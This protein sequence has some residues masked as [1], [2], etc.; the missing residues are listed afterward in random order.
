M[1]GAAN[2][3]GLAAFGVDF[4]H[5]GSH[6]PGGEPVRKIG[7]SDLTMPANLKPVAPQA[8]TASR[9]VLIPVP[10]V[11]ALRRLQYD[12]IRK[13][14]DEG[15][16]LF[17][18]GFV[19]VWNFASRPDGE[20]DL[21]FWRDEIEDTRATA[22]LALDDVLARILPLNRRNYHAGQVT[23]LF[24]LTPNSLARLRRQL[25]GHVETS[26]AVFPRAGLESFLRKRW[27]GAACG[28]QNRNGGKS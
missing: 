1:P 6:R 14:V 5:S 11:R 22:K 2:S 20:R 25:G 27:L 13:L 12:A 18:P 9:S 4:R 26:G 8:N 24:M 16:D 19:W 10:G 17:N 15:G 21:R 23:E 7:F 28:N 3:S